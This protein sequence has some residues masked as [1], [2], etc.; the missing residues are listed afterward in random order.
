MASLLCRE[1]AGAAGIKGTDILDAH[2]GECQFQSILVEQNRKLA[3]MLAIAIQHVLKSRQQMTQL[4][5]VDS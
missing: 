1:D 3:V 2:C 4:Y 5:G